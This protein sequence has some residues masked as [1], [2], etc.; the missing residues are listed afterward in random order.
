[1][2][3][4]WTDDGMVFEYGVPLDTPYHRELRARRTQRRSA[5]YLAPIPLDWVARAG[6]LP[7]RALAVALSLR[8]Q[9]AL[10]K[11]KRLTGQWD[12]LAKDLMDLDRGAIDRGLKEL[13]TAGLIEIEKPGPG[14]KRVIV[15]LDG[16]NK[17]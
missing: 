2:S 11:S 16:T 17:R 10:R 7:G 13:N 5:A 3:R 4:S 1:M 6:K 12:H 15:I 8:H 9:S 14:M